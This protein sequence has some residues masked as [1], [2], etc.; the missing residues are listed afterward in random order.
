MIIIDGV[1]PEILHM[2]AEGGESHSH[3]DPRNGDATDE[4]LFLIRN[5]EDG[6]RWFVGIIQVIQTRI[7]IKVL[8]LW[9]VI[10]E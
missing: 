8:V 3:I 7:I 9:F 5:F 6:S 4:L 1:E 2:P 10:L